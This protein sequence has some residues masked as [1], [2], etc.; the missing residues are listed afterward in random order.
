MGTAAVRVILLGHVEDLEPAWLQ[1]L[2]AIVPPKQYQLP[3][4]EKEITALTAEPKEAQVLCET[5]F[6]SPVC[7]VHKT[8]GA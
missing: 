8:S 7:L 6:S 5:L 1:V 4:E 2:S 3:R